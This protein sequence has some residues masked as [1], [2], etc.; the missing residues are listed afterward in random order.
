MRKKIRYFR[1]LLFI[2][3]IILFLSCSN[4]AIAQVI[5]AE[6]IARAR[7]IVSK[8]TQKEKLMYIS[9]YKDFSIYSIPRLGLPEIKMADGPQGIRN[10]TQSTMYPAGILSA[11][12]WNRNLIRQLG[13]SLGSDA[14]AR[15]VGI[16]LGPGVNMYRSPMCG[17][18]FEYFGEDP[19]LSSEVAKE[20]ILG[21]QSEGVIA[22]IK[23]FALNNQEWDR[24]DT[25]SDADERTMQELYFSTF[26]KAVQQAHVGAVMNSYNLINGV[27]ATEN[28]WMN[29]D[30]L[31][32]QWGFK[33]ILM[34][35]WNSVY[36]GVGAANGGLDLEMP[37]GLFV[38]EAN[39]LPA[40]NNGL[41]SEATINLKVQHI[42][43]TLI[44]FGM[45]D[46][47]L[48]DGIIPK[49]NV[50]SRQVAL[51]L[52]REG[53][54]L[55][56]NDAHILPLVGTTA[57]MGP[58][59]NHIP[60]GGGSGF[61][62]PYSTVT[63]W[64]GMQDAY[65]KKVNLISDDM[66]IQDLK[67][68]MSPF[69]AEYY[70]NQDLEGNPVIVRMESGINY[71]WKSGVPIV[72]LPEDHFSVRWSAT[73]KAPA[74]EL[75]KLHVEGDD[76][77][78]LFVNDTLLVGDWGDHGITS[79]EALL[80]VEAG[81]EYAF[82]VEYYDNI[83]DAAIRFHASILNEDVLKSHLQSMKNVV[84]CV[85]FDSSTESEGFDRTFSLPE[86]Q[87]LLIDNICSFHDNVIVVLNAGGGV[88]FK[89]WIDKVKAVVM[90][91]YPGQEGG[92]ALAEILTGKIS[93]SGRLP[94]SMEEKWEDNPV[95]HS[96]YD[97]GSM[98]HH[99]V[100]YSEGIFTG[101][102]GYDQFGKKP[103][104]PFGF[105]L[106]YTTFSYHNLELE[107][108][109]V[110]KVKVSF[111]LKNTGKVDA[112]EVAQIYVRDVK[113]SVPRPLK[114]LKGYEKVFLKHGETKRMNVELDKEAFSYYDVDKKD[115]IVEPGE[116][117]IL[118]GSS[119][120]EL[121]LKRMI[122]W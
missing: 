103:L 60:M 28:Q 32:K 84:L 104:F 44:A 76:G 40:I 89:P 77:Y 59:A 70:A 107:K 31:R 42:L 51:E 8:M 86:W 111:D 33:G 112:S 12:T 110:D 21:V 82:R 30:V 34:S 116:F 95:Y 15:G 26:R 91:W 46:G 47:K 35:D 69:K 97:N 67:N 92:R 93:P 73:Y 85:G 52:A 79:R 22:T 61:V 27:H 1:I 81:K 2:S 25:S 36:S 71:D 38:N 24:H 20:Y 18:N 50:A 120:E 6:D 113:A 105:G 45:L 90:A 68:G 96:Y 62:N 9:G 98:P 75:I 121:P 56:K 102:R 83:R 29:I 74:K 87:E 16:L 54:V 80:K 55:L 11:S 13:K 23:H 106:S 7:E 19:Y 37:S 64:A 10:D 66:W 108:F 99:R 39:L 3:A 119:S 115:F 17:R 122:E 114:E 48:G 109:G 78:R 53:I 88:N 5:S 117:E 94:I 101:Y 57:I 100:L 49:D 43:Q 41:V 63:L 14:K 65:K 58:N 4:T 118:V 72:G